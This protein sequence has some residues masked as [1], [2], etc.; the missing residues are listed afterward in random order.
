MHDC[1]CTLCVLNTY[2]WILRGGGGEGAS[3]C[4]LQYKMVEMV[5]NNCAG[6]M[7]YDN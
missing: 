6:K 5:D 4:S 3:G 2:K 7:S 1:V